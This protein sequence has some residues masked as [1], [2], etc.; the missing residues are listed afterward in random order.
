MRVITKGRIPIKVWARE[1]EPGAMSQAINLAN[2]PFAFHHVALMPDVHEGYGMPI[3]GVL[4]TEGVIIPN[5][6]GVDIG[7]GVIACKTDIQ[8]INQAEIKK[9][10]KRTKESIPMGFQHHQKPQVWH[11]FEQA[12]KIK[13]IQQELASAR[14][15]LGSLG[16][17]N[18]FIE[19]QKGDDGHL[20]LM[21]HSGSRNL[22]LKVAKH[23][24]QVAKKINGKSTAPIPVEYDLAF[25]PMDSQEGEEYFAAM[26]FCLDFA[27]ANRGLLANRFYEIF[28]EITGS[29]R[30]E[31]QVDIHHNYA[32]PETHFGRKVIIHRKGATSAKEKELGIIPGSMGTPSYLV[33][34]LGNPESFMSCSHGAGRAMSRREANKKISA[35]AA[36]RSMEGIMF[37][38]W[39]GDYSE[40]PMAYKDIEIVMESQRDLVRPR[41]KLKPLAVI[42]G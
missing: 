17:G 41:V 7:C 11:G 24:N 9:L 33:E 14:C 37:S 35:E 3:G 22:G 28:A 26:S 30:I 29:Q 40:A 12:P 19:L 1:L 2:F 21:L 8:E 31:Q 16:G 18:H 10:L 27:K 20:W 23:Y 32:A 25:L 6:V 42:K 4:A 34:G 13:I 39:R 5:A 36:N 38:G 15:Q